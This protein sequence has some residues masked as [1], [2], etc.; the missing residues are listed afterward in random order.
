[1]RGVA[2]GP[3]RDGR[4][5]AARPRGPGGGD[6]RTRQLER[7][8]HPLLARSGI[9]SVLR[10]GRDGGVGNGLPA[11]APVTDARTRARDPARSRGQGRAVLRAGER[12]RRR[13]RGP[14]PPPAAVRGAARGP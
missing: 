13:R 3:P 6:L 4:F 7:S 9:R 2:L 8:G 14:W 5:A 11:P 1:P 10:G 12:W